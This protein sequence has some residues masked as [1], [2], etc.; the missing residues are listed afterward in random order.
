MLLYCLRHGESI[1]NAEGRIQ[2]Q[3]D[4]PLSEFGRRQGEA[5][6]AA[7]AHLPIEAIYSSPLRRA[8]QTALPL[9]EALKL[10]IRTDVR[11][12]EVHAGIFQD[13]LRSELEDLYPEVMARWRGGDPDFAIPGGE[14]RRVLMHRGRKVFHEIRE[15]G[16]GN[17]VVVTHGG[18][19]SAVL[20]SLLEIPAERNPFTL[21]NGSITRLD[22]SDGQVKLLSLNQ[23]E[24][25]HDMGPSGSGD[26]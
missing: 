9:A 3:S 22:W 1:Y 11:L 20:K 17:V 12:M 2:G 4:V 8:M 14:S 6:A 25:L 5:A 19:L 26:L 18:L 10:P 13:K 16:H 23:V 15:T 7:L 21:Q 24:H